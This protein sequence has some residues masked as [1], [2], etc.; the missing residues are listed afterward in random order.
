MHRAADE[1]EGEGASEPITPPES[2]DQLLRDLAKKGAVV[3]PERPQQLTP[4]DVRVIVR[5]ET[6][7][8][9]VLGRFITGATDDGIAELDALPDDCLI[10]ATGSYITGDGGFTRCWARPVPS[11]VI[12]DDRRLWQVL[13]HGAS[14]YMSSLVPSSRIGLAQVLYVGEVVSGD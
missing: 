7:R 14:D 13:V 1:A 5:E 8:S 6:T 12:G 3:L 4:A 10:E 11:H 2:D 9:Q